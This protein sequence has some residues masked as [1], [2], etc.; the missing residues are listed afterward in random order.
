MAVLGTLTVP[1]RQ[2]RAAQAPHAPRPGLRLSGRI[3]VPRELHMVRVW[4]GAVQLVLRSS[5][6][7]RGD[8]DQVAGGGAVVTLRTE[9]SSHCAGHRSSEASR[10]HWS[11]HQRRPHPPLLSPQRRRHVK[12]SQSR[13][14]LPAPIVL[15]GDVGTAARSNAT[16]DDRRCRHAFINCNRRTVRSPRWCPGVRLACRQ[17]QFEGP[18]QPT[19]DSA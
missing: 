18:Q 9:L 11:V 3:C 1:R 8:A 4:A 7:I 15:G 17:T 12:P 16:W 19:C 14:S 10:G 5:V 13:G 6:R 2:A